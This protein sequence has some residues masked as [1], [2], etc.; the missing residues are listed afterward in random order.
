M[1]SE[2]DKPSTHYSNLESKILSQTTAPS[3]P[4]DGDT[5]YDTDDN[6]LCIYNSTIAQWRCKN[7]STTT[8]SST[9]TTSTSTSTTSTSSSTS[10]TTSIST[11][12]TTSTT[13]TL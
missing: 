7:F 11:S 1:S 12:I 3:E 13:T 9:S 2:I 6:K 4:L 5:Y 8:S 10:M